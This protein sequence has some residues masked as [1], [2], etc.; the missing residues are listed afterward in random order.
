M[1][2][3][4]YLV[5][6]RFQGKGRHTPLDPIILHCFE[7]LRPIPHISFAGWLQTND[8]AR[9]VKDFTVLCQNTPFCSCKVDKLSSNESKSGIFDRPRVIYLHIDSTKQFKNFRW[10]LAQTIFEYFPHY[11]KEFYFH[12]TL[13]SKM[14]V[15]S[16]NYFWNKPD[17]LSFPEPHFNKRFFLIRATLIKNDRILCEYD[18]LQR[19]IFT[20]EEASN[21]EL[22]LITK[23]LFGDFSNAKYDPDQNLKK[24]GII[25]KIKN[26]FYGFIN[27]KKSK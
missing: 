17:I 12:D 26:V 16:S 10:N 23:K 7:I 25:N 14:K 11:K 22:L 19:R 1:N 4:N 27:P 13:V 21:R 9:F 20:S 18:F 5:E 15:T 2:Y 24:R 8:E 6:Y 3:D